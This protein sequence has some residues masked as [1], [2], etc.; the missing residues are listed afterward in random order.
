[1]PTTTRVYLEQGAKRTFAC[2]LDWPGWARSARSDDGAV[3][4]LLGHAD[5]YSVV[6]QRAGLSFPRSI[7]VDV[8]ERVPGSATTDFGAPGSVATDDLD[9]LSPARLRRQVALLDASWAVFAEVVAAAPAELRKGPRGGGRDR[10]EVVR[11]VEEAE[12][13]YVRTIGVRAKPFRSP[14]DVVA[15]RADVLEVLR[16]GAPDA[17]WPVAYLIRRTAWHVLDHT[18]EIE[19]RSA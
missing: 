19:D 12:R 6:A 9:P 14:A 17:T 15:L 8:V 11:H 5:R 18:W 3:E 10:D 2:A 7:T 16:S 1:V 13:S 4:A